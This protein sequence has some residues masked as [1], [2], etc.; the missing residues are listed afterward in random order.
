MVGERR[1]SERVTCSGCS[2]AETVFAKFCSRRW[3]AQVPAVRR[4]KPHSSI[5]FSWS[6]NAAELRR[7]GTSDTVEGKHCNFEL[8]PLLDRQ[9]AVKRVA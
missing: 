9:P 2:N 3:H 7:A 6:E 1:C 5:N 8:N 4:T